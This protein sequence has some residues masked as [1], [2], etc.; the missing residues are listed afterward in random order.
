LHKLQRLMASAVM[1]PLGHGDNMQRRWID[2]RPTTKIAED[3]IK[4]NDRLTSFERLEIYNR[5]YW[6]RL[7][8]CFCK[9]YPGL[10]AI[11]GD[12]RFEQLTREYLTRHPSHSYTMRNLGSRLV[13]FLGTAPRQQP[14]LDMA[15][16]EW[17]HIE[18][19]DNEGS[20]PLRPEDLLDT[21]AAKIR[22][23]LQPHL[24]LLKLQW[25]VDEFL[26]SLK[27]NTSL[28]H[29]ASNAME[30]RRQRPQRRLN[31]K[32]K[33]TDIFLAVHRYQ[34]RVHYKRLDPGQFRILSALHNGAT[35]A[36]AFASFTSLKIS[37]DLGETINGWFSSWAT[38]GWFCG[39]K[40]P[41]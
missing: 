17:A 27:N 7:R 38:L 8:D 31:Q 16:L 2:G 12:R 36:E 39:L 19:F 24:T 13:K 6:F 5:Q 9:D 32:L 21:D 33:R 4:P 35:L 10:H 25:E 29:E 37:G 11:L 14:A 26:L 22:L 23:R 41:D 3:F 34:D 30:R 15:R 1:R 28:R 40:R 18:A 20:P